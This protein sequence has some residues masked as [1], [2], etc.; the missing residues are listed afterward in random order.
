LGSGKVTGRPTFGDGYSF[1]D[2]R[3]DFLEE[4][5]MPLTQLVLAKAIWLLRQR[6]LPEMPMSLGS[7]AR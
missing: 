3:A 6:C 5:V 7:A 2:R 1:A 4:P